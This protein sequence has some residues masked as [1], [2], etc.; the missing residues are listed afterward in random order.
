MDLL[1]AGQMNRRTSA[2]AMN[3]GS[4]RSHS[5]FMITL[6]QKDEK[7]GVVKNSKINL[8]DLAGSEKVK[9]TAATGARLEEAKMINLSLSALGNVIK[10]L[11]EHHGK[12]THIPYPHQ[13][14]S[15]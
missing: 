4:S 13:N 11:T 14:H 5:I 1:Y 3:E 15:L 8:V 7:T 9:K 10:A 2:T 12:N 6:I